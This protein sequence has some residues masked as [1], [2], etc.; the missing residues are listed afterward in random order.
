MGEKRVI[1]IDEVL[2][3]DLSELWEE[4]ERQSLRGGL[5]GPGKRLHKRMEVKKL[6]SKY[7]FCL[8]TVMAYL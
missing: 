1:L 6:W 3:D 2:G 5:P 7:L 8:A 4:S